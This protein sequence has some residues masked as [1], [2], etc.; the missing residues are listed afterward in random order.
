MTHAIHLDFETYSALDLKRCGAWRYSVDP[1]TEVLYCCW[2]VGE[3]DV[4]TWC[5]ALIKPQ[6]VKLGFPSNWHYGPTIPKRL[7]DAVSQGYLFYAHNAQFERYIWENILVRRHGAPR[8]QRSQF[9]CTAV[10]AAA[11]GL[12][13]KLEFAA[14]ALG[15]AQQ[16]DTEGARLIKLFCQ[17]KKVTKKD[18]RSRIFPADNPLQFIRFGEYCGQDVRTERDIDKQIPQLHPNIQRL[19]ELDMLVNERGVGLD[20]PLVKRAAVIV[21]QLEGVI[22][23][24]VQVITKCE[25]FPEGL[26]PTQRDKMMQFFSSIGVEL[27][28][29]QADY[30]RKFVRANLRSLAPVAKELLILRIEAGK[31][32]TKKFAAMLAYADPRDNR[33]RGTFLMFGGHTGRFSSRGVQFQ[34]VIRGNLKFT[35]VLRIFALLAKADAEGFS[36]L[37]EWPISAISQ[38]MRG[39]IIPGAGRI[40]RVVDYSA[41][42]ARVLA[43]LAQ[44]EEILQ[45]YRTGLDVYKVM[46][47]QL[48]RV[49]YDAVTDEQ[50]RIGKTIIL[51]CGYGLGAVKFV[52]YCEKNGIEITE[53]LAKLAVRTYRQERR[54]IVTFWYD[55][56]RAAILAVRENRTYE[57]HVRLRNLKFFI[58]DKWFCIE[59]PSGRWLRY[60]Q[61]RVRVVDKFGEPAF[62]LS[63][64]VEF[65]G[66]LVNESTYGGKLVENMTQAVALD[67]LVNGMFEAEKEGYPVIGTVH[68][69]LL[70]EPKIGHGSFKHLEEIVSRIPP[71]ATGCPISAQG[72]ESYRYRKS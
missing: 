41:I 5:P 38:C 49:P 34:N 11:A 2:A 43:W 25:Q 45:A 29:M 62:Q 24:R 58:D 69:E 56:E 1:S 31:S 15:T 60:Y 48:F 64:K 61:P 66:R 33:A 63:Y 40:L 23:T 18:P 36:M 53:E 44:D 17:P 21:R 35:E 54:K 52:V 28:N 47:A 37:Y 3:D 70:T 59:L 46:A 8:S 55:V 32:S 6:A 57:N 26:R 67:L 42:E 13:R 12:P 14:M 20:I 22:N 30:I 10:R 19:F 65:R 71:W 7:A 9:R 50:R 4:Q 27:E 72:F 68:D 39:F 16:K 51:G